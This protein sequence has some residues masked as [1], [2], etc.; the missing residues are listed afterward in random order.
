[1]SLLLNIHSFGQSLPDSGFTDRAEAK[2]ETVNGVKQGKWVEFVDNGDR[3]VA[4]EKYAVYCLLIV[5]KDGAPYGLLRKYDLG[6]KQLFW[7]IPYSG[8]KRNGIMKKYYYYNKRIKSE[9]PYVNDTI[10]GIVKDYYEATC[11]LK[12]ETP[13]SHNLMNG[14]QKTYSVDGKTILTESTYLGGKKN[15]LTKDYYADGKLQYVILYSDNIKNGI[16]KM[17]EEDG[18]EAWEVTYVNGKLDDTSVKAPQGST[19]DSSR[20]SVGNISGFV[21]VVHPWC[22]DVLD[23]RT[24]A[25]TKPR[26]LPNKKMYIRRGD[27]NDF[28]KPIVKEFT[29]D[30]DGSFNV[31]LPPGAYVIIAENKLNKPNCDSLLSKYANGSK[32][33]L[34]IKAS[35]TVCINRWYCEPDAAF[36]V[37]N[38]CIKDISIIYYLPCSF[39]CELPCLRPRNI[40]Q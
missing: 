27:S 33:C 5:Y 22:T 9:I 26:P 2:N 23:S 10:C 32:N 24:D 35:D 30:S 37:G 1:M 11:N 34:P 13:Y 7:T 15:G 36:I 4:S 6:T 21:K 14:I 17:Y 20:N 29:T 25:Y 39:E 18:K 19:P 28:S 16:E 3:P 38:N 12:C 8:G 40:M 31:S